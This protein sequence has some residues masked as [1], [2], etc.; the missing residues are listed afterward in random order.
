MAFVGMVELASDG[1]KPYVREFARV[2]KVVTEDLPY[3]TSGCHTW[4]VTLKIPKDLPNSH[5]FATKDKVYKIAYEIRVAALD[6]GKPMLIGKVR[7]SIVNL[8]NNNE[9]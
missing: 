9:V 8:R 7:P 3:S 6:K 5:I 2:D 1:T 4:P